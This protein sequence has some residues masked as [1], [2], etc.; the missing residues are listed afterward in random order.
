MT[1]FEKKLEDNMKVYEQ[2]KEVYDEL[3]EEVKKRNYD[4]I[5]DE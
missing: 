1:E 3:N 4:I 2:A 5:L